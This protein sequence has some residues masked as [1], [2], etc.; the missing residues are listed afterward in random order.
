MDF[1]SSGF[2]FSRDLVS[3]VA[4]YSSSGLSLFGKAAWVGS[5]SALVLLIPLRHSLIAE[6][7]FVKEQEMHREQM[8]SDRCGRARESHFT[9]CKGLFS[10]APLALS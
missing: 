1:L 2:R 3:D 8:R 5:V 10:T 9:F 4:A 7:Q 6:E